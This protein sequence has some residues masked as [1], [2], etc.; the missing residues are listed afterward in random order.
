M[1]TKPMKIEAAEMSPLDMVDGDQV[2]VAAAEVCE[3]FGMSRTTLW[4]SISQGMPSLPIGN[5]HHRFRIDQV[6]LWLEANK[7][8][9]FAEIGRA[10][11]LQMMR[12]NVV[13]MLAAN[14]VRVVPISKIPVFP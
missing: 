13:R 12:K 6:Q 4:R 14:G 11:T 7:R 3:H 1:N 10:T 8:T 5:R 2:Y 9:R